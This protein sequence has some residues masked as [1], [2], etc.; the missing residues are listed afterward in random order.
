MKSDYFRELQSTLVLSL[1]ALVLSLSG[2][3]TCSWT[4]Y[5]PTYPEKLKMER[6]GEENEKAENIL[7]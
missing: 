4:F 7:A 6:R 3:V 1:I 2:Y 5:E